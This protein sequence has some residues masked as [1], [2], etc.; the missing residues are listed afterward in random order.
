MTTDY[1]WLEPVYLVEGASRALSVEFEGASTITSP[2]AEVYDAIDGSDLASTYM[3]AGSHSVN[4]NLVTLKPF[5]T[6][7][8]QGGKELVLVIYATVDGNVDYRKCMV[9]IL[10]KTV[11]Y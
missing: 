9:Y 5:V 8:A 2:G 10:D 1:I 11:P 3:P 7:A 4:G 6:T